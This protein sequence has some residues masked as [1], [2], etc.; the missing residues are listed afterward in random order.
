MATRRATVGSPELAKL[1]DTYDIES[2]LQR[3]GSTATWVARQKD[4]GKPVTV[5]VVDAATPAERNAL[6]HL[7]ADARLL[8]GA[9]HPHVVPVIDTRWLAAT[10]LAIIRVRVRGTTLRHALDSVG[11][12]PEARVIEIL[13][14]VGDVLSWASGSGIANRQ[15]TSDSICFQKGSGKVMVSF[16]LPAILEKSS[17]AAAATTVPERCADGATLARLGYEMLT[18]HQSLDASIDNLHAVRQD[19]SPRVVEAISAGLACRTGSPPLDARRFVTM[20]TGEAPAIGAAAIATAASAPVV[21]RTATSPVPPP[22]LPLGGP[23]VGNPHHGEP[24]PPA[25][26]TP[27]AEAKAPP[28]AALEPGGAPLRAGYPHPGAA[29]PVGLPPR[30]RR[31]GRGLLLTSMLALLVLVGGTFYLISR[32]RDQEATRLADNRDATEEA[33]DVDVEPLPADPDGLIVGEATA[34]EDSARV[35]VPPAATTPPPATE[36]APPVEAAP[37]PAPREPEPAPAPRP[38]NVCQSPDPA[39]QRTCLDQRLASRDAELNSVYQ[40]LVQAVGERQGSTAV[41]ALRSEQRAWLVDRDRRC[42]GAGSGALWAEERADCLGRI[43]DARAFSLA[44]EL[45]RVR[46]AP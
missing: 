5:T 23:T 38:A 46:S 6:T 15:L 43:S 18:A 40:A 2:E 11:P 9:R 8:A 30:Q 35:V 7:A 24:T 41:E 44:R 36:P 14:D 25:D 45:A 39:D 4:G 1:A 13:K 10:R 33:G 16:G 3:S 27:P 12:M 19:V 28:E 34:P 20:L 42:Q 31:R 29:A 26:A 37:E 17:A 21:P 22:Q 32:D